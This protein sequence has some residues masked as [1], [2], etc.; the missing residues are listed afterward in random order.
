MESTDRRAWSDT[1]LACM[2][3]GVLAA[4]WAWRDWANL[5]V[6][7]LPDADDAMRLQQIRDWLS[8]Q[9]FGDVTQYRLGPGGTAMH[10][11]RLD[12]LVPAALI[13]LFEGVL[14]RH[15]AEVAAVIA[16]PAILLAAAIALTARIARRLGG[17]ESVM[18]AMI[19]AAIAY[20]A[21]TL[22]APGRI[23]HHNLQMVLVLV[24]A[25]ALVG[26]STLRAGA[27]AGVAA[28]LS[29]VVGMET[30]PLLV[31]A[32]AVVAIDWVVQGVP[33][34]ARLFGFGFGLGGAILLSSA[35]FATTSWTLPACDG[36]TA[37][38]MR[39]AL[40]AAVVPVALALLPL[41]SRPGRG[42][43]LAVAGASLLA[44][45]MLAAPQC[46]SPYGGVDPLL[47]QLWLARVG[48]AVPLA[49]APLAV[50]IGY[51]GLMVAGI[52]ATGW[53]I[54]TRRDR[55]WLAML[56]LQLAA[57]AVTFLQVRGAYAGALLAAPALGALIL[58]A[59][60]RGAV[61]LAGAW[62][63]SAGMLYPIAAQALVPAPPSSAGP[64]C[65]SPALI[66]ALAGQPAGIVMAPIDTGGPA[67]AATAQRFV[68]G[69]YHRDND[70][71]LAMYR[72]YLGRPDRARAIAARLGVTYVIACDGFA[73]TPPRTSLAA[74]LAAGAGPDWLIRVQTMSDGAALY[75][76]RPGLSAPRLTR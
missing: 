68:A 54:W 39:A 6:L 34:R 72:F 66:A 30:A 18:P 22:F 3:A 8:G 23:D 71:N 70:G 63:A 65:T 62:I 29:L 25:W 5:S 38:V 76:V 33:A 9:A 44:A 53:Q 36:F 55:C 14:G 16:W 64:S 47:R 19:V 21:S 11:S 48:E 49:G 7:R 58:A 26:P 50:A 15:G 13:R 12:D 52:A 28:A 32:A 61:A 73:G 40:L 2:L 24:M 46:L 56:A 60:R 67:I 45:V 74:Q 35:A 42:I 31:A 57:L 41:D 4:A 69:A 75:R 20:P 27:A 17:A 10:W 1:L 43:A 59:R 51:A 37:I